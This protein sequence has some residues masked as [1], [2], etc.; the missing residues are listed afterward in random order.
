MAKRDSGEDE[1]KLVAGGPCG[2]SG[3]L[4]D[5]WAGA[6]LDAS[7]RGCIVQGIAELLGGGVGTDGM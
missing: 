6:G 7:G 3:S 2:L 1:M 5:R 4:A